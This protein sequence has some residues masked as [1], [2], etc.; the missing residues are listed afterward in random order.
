MPTLRH[1]RQSTKSTIVYI[2][3]F[4]LQLSLKLKGDCPQVRTNR[5]NWCCVCDERLS[6]DDRSVFSVCRLLSACFLVFSSSPNIKWRRNVTK[7]EVKSPM[8]ALLIT[9]LYYNDNISNLGDAQN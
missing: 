4:L 3:T 1:E 6:G 5:D 7:Y 2:S 9:V 8:R